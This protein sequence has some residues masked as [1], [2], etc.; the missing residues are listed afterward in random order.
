MTGARA[1]AV[2]RVTALALI[3]GGAALVLVSAGHGG[4]HGGNHGGSGT[5]AEAWLAGWIWLLSITAGAGLWLLIGALTG[6]RW[7]HDGR[8]ALVPLA[9][10]TPLTALLGLGLLAAAPVLYPW[11]SGSEGVRGKIYLA[12]TPFAIRTVLALVLWS[13]IGLLASRRLAAPVAALLLIAHGVLVSLV[14]L[15]WLLSMDQDFGSTTFGAL[16]TVQ[17]LGMALAAGM[18]SGLPD[19]GDVRS[20]WGGL[21]LACVL[22]VF[23]LAA[24]QFLVKWSGDLPADARW[25]AMRNSGSGLAPVALVL[26]AILPFSLL[27]SGK[28]RANPK[29]LRAIATSVLAGGFLHIAWLVGCGAESLFAAAGIVLVGAGIWQLRPVR[30]GDGP[31]T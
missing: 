17:Q 29:V 15:D 18:L 24:M 27:L 19:D 7:I 21:L 6:G 13:L 12:P 14:G 25:Y 20:D 3:L 11:W 10:A 30:R 8:A 16:F 1:L 9:H 26:G 5:L 4:N 31:T 23:Y 28:M 2:G 22:G